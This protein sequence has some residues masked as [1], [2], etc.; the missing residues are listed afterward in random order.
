V[1][2]ACRRLGALNHDQIVVLPFE[3]GRGKVRGAG[4]QHV[5]KYRTAAS[6][7]RWHTIG[8]HGSPWTPDMARTE[9][10]RILVEVVGELPYRFER[11]TF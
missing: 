11:M 6:R 1:L 10:R 3:A 5:L 7:Q 4:A 2:E 9:A 8:R